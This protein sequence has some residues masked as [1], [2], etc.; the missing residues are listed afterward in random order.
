MAQL[1]SFTL[2]LQPVDRWKPVVTVPNFQ[3]LAPQCLHPRLA[4]PR[5][6]SLLH[7][8]L[9][10]ETHELDDHVDWSPLELWK[11]VFEL[12][13]LVPKVA[14]RVLEPLHDV[15]QRDWQPTVAVDTPG[16]L[17]A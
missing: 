7:L 16:T 2:L 15:A 13:H 17:A 9:L 5:W 3:T 6:Q 12:H 8:W 1:P 14:P 11:P 10:R 4:R